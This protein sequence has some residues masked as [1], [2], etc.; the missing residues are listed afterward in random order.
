MTQPTTPPVTPAPEAPKAEVSAR[1]FFQ[2]DDSELVKIWAPEPPAEEPAAPVVETPVAPPSAE[3]VPTDSEGAEAKAPEVEVPKA[4]RKLMTEFKVL[5]T[6]GELEVPEIE[7]EFKAKGEMRKL[8]LDHVVRLAQ[9]GFANEEREQQVLASKRFVAEAQ[10]KEQQ[11]HQTIQQYEQY[12]EKMFNDP[13][14]YEEA[15]LAFIN[16]NSPE[17]RA[18]RAEGE[19][20]RQRQE[21]LVERE[22]VQRAEFT[23]QAVVPVVTRLLTENPLVN[24][25]EIIGR[26]STLTAP[27]LVQGKVPLNRLRE[28]EHVVQNDLTTWAQQTQYERTLAKQESDRKAAQATHQVAQAKRQAARVFAQPGQVPEPQPKPTKFETAKD[29]L[30]A[31]LPTASE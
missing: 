27:F 20:A 18:Q 14:F 2:Q 11:F 21:K 5:D 26:F 7:I 31:T 30:N 25:N 15:R 23:Q 9:F 3:T 4:E 13:A 19:L 16:Q 6:E 10:E 17:A 1:E 22:N 24:E 12:Y 28:V 29:W 8:P